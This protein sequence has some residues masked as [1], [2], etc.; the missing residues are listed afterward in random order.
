MH[1]YYLEGD[2][3]E[4]KP[5]FHIDFEG[6]EDFQIVEMLAVITRHINTPRLSKLSLCLPTILSTPETLPSL[7][8]ILSE[9]NNLRVFSFVD[10][11]PPVLYAI[12]SSTV[13]QPSVHNYCG[14][15]F[16]KLEDIFVPPPLRGR[17][18][19]GGIPFSLQNYIDILLLLLGMRE[20]QG[21]QIPNFHVWHWFVLT[22]TICHDQQLGL[23][24][25]V[26]RYH[27]GNE[28]GCKLSRPLLYSHFLHMVLPT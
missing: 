26:L 7:L 17:R 8:T 6:V 25:D 4:D 14:I 24:K 9:M 10:C 16:P 18:E 19:D 1:K 3:T 5:Y 13:T 12:L 2:D 22:Q 20:C 28:K 23:W 27:V 11:P 15:I 21:A